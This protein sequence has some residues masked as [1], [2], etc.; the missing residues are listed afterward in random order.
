MYIYQIST[1]R[2]LNLCNVIYKLYVNKTGL[3]KENVVHTNTQTHAQN[4]QARK[5]NKCIQNVNVIFQAQAQELQRLYQGGLMKKS[6]P[7]LPYLMHK[8]LHLRL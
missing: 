4:N 1:L 7:P 8:S 2:I 3:K 5:R 6:C